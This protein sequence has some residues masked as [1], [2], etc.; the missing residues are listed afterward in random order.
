[1]MS[2]KAKLIELDEESIKELKEREMGLYPD[3]EEPIVKKENSGREERKLFFEEIDDNSHVGRVEVNPEIVPSLCEFYPPS[4]KFLIRGASTKEIRDFSDYVDEDPSTVNIAINN[5]LKSLIQ[6]TSHKGRMSYKSILELDKIFFIIALRDLT[7]YKMPNVLENSS[8]CPQC[9]DPCGIEIYSSNSTFY[10]KNEELYK[11]YDFEKRN[12]T[13]ELKEG[14]VLEIKPPS[15][16]VSEVVNNY[17]SHKR[18]SGQKIEVKLLENIKY[19]DLDWEKMTVERLDD[20]LVSMVGW[21]N[22]RYTL[23]LKFI[24]DFKKQ[25]KVFETFGTCKSC[26]AQGVTVPFQF[27]Q[28][29]RSIFLVSNP[30]SNI[31]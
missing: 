26:G 17:I 5:L 13:L 22:E 10:K 3:E 30:Y 9:L 2:E 16:L 31:R 14:T 12:F 20:F 19:L 4:M 18:N 28:N 27:H 21:S 29:F 8:K 1:M 24:D 6:V 25:F 15:I 11:F 7:F 23:F